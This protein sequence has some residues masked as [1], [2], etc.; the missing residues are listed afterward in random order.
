METTKQ[1]SG[2]RL[3]WPLAIAL[4]TLLILVGLAIWWRATPLGARFILD[5]PGEV[6]LPVDAPVGIPA[7]LGWQHF[8]NAFF[9]VLIVRTGMKFRA[10]VRSGNRP[11]AFWSPKTTKPGHRPKRISTDLWLHNVVD[12]FWMVNGVVFVILLIATGQWMRIVPITWEVI[13]NAFSAAVQ[14]LSLN[15]PTT[16]TW[17]NYN[18]LQQ[19]AYFATVFLAAPLAVLTGFRLSSLWSENWTGLTRAFPD[20][21]ARRIHFPVMLYF[22]AF[23]VV[24]VTLVLTTGAIRNL[25]HMFGANDGTSLLGLG[26]FAFALAAMVAAWFLVRTSVIKPIAARFGTVR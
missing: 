22:V 13:P 5:Y 6:P 26:M 19:L 17:A 3:L 25:N 12:V 14:Y 18:S 15:W 24:H 7:W 4:V 20:S 21:V 2:A 10:A 9:L 23:T 8:L 1:A 16:N 11:E